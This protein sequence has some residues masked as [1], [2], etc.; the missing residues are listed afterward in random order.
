MKTTRYIGLVLSVL[1]P[2]L[3]FAQ[4]HWGFAATEVRYRINDSIVHVTFISRVVDL[5]SL[6]C[7]NHI[8]DDSPAAEIYERYIRNWFYDRIHEVNNQ[9][10]HLNN[11]V[12][13]LIDK[14]DMMGDVELYPTFKRFN[15]RFMGVPDNERISILLDK[16]MADKKRNAFIEIASQS[17]S[18]V[19]LIP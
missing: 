3:S 15:E 5:S 19:I 4:N 6:T 10:L 1:L 12:I 18:A 2:F 8:N 16:E 17:T 11:D 7:E 14:E 9:I 13:H